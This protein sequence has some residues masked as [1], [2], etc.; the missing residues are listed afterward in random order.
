[1]KFLDINIETERNK[2]DR[3]KSMITT[4][5]NDPLRSFTVL[6]CNHTYHIYDPYQLPAKQ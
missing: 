5:K 6:S 2:Y 3:L 1:M 4:K